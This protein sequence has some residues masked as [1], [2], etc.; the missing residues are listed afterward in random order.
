MIKEELLK[1]YT[2]TIVLCAAAFVMAAGQWAGKWT[3][4]VEGWIM[5]GSAAGI[6]LRLGV[7][8]S[9]K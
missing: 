5:V 1:Y 7:G 3:I 4:P 9:I 2:K 8:K 6:A